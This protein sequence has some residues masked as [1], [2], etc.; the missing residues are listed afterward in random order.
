MVIGTTT[1]TITVTDAAGNT[2]TR[3]L[4]AIRSGVEPPP[5]EE[6]AISSEQVLF[7]AAIVALFIVVMVFVKTVL[8]KKRFL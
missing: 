6:P 4:N 5:E 1:F 7:I 3:T 8:V 2:T